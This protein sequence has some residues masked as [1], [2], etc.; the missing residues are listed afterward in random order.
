MQMY[1]YLCIIQVLGY[2]H[3]KK[4]ISYTDIILPF[5][6]FISFEK[7]SVISKCVFM[8]GIPIPVAI[9]FFSVFI[10]LPVIQ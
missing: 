7:H 3:Q 8:V 10:L 9:S 2:L 5:I 6:P 4:I 1:V